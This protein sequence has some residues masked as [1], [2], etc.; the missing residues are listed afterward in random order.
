MS[1]TKEISER[2]NPRRVDRSSPTPLYQQLGQVL[3]AE[4]EAGV[5]RVGD[6][7]PSEHVICTR[8]GVSRSVTRSTL[9]SLAQDGFIRTERGRGSFVVEPKLSEGFVQQAAGFYDDMTRMGLDIRTRVLRQEITDVPMAVREFL[10]VTRAMRIDRVRSVGGKL[11]V[12]VVTYLPPQLCPGLEHHDLTDR[13]LYAHLE[14]TYGLKLHS[15]DRTVEAVPAERESAR[16]LEVPEG[17]PLLLLRS[18][19]LMANGEPLEWFE[20]WHRGDRSRFDFRMV[21]GDQPVRALA[22]VVPIDDTRGAG[23]AAASPEVDTVRTIYRAFAGQLERDKVV[24]VVRAPRYGDGAVIAEAL[25]DGGVRMVEFTLT[26]SNSYE[27]IEKARAVSGVTVGVG[28]VLDLASARRAVEAGAQFIVCPAEVPELA[29]AFDD[30]PVVLAGFTPSE[31]LRAH[32]LTGGPVMLFPAS[33]GG[34]SYVRAVRAT[35]PNIPLMPSDGVDA[36]NLA[37]YLAAGAVAVSIGAPLCPVDAV[38]S[39]DAAELTRR[40]SRVRAAIDESRH[41]R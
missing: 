3:R 7:L 39:A 12:Y 30:I 37:E 34:P 15:G 23:E 41:G 33:A 19:G 22:A 32:R 21:P 6:M 5:Y 20:A 1:M 14:S 8:Y 4:I 40:A 10:G 25:R 16:Y 13:S 2:R 17:T 28:T 31:I 38:S 24:A 9:Q 11:V 29:G 35:M 26:G 18:R 27:A 36:S